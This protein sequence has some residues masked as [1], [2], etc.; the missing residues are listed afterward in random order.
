MLDDAMATAIVLMVEGNDDEPAEPSAAATLG[1]FVGSEGAT[2][3]GFSASTS[4]GFP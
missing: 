4:L 2:G 1:D 3:A